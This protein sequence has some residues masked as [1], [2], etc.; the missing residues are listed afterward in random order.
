MFV[1]VEY[2]HRM[3]VREV[4]MCVTVRSVCGGIYQVLL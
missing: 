4:Y 2:R 1:E 3:L